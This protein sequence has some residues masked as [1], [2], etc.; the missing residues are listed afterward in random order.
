MLRSLLALSLV[1][2]SPPSWHPSA[3][4][5]GIAPWEH[6]EVVKVQ[7]DEGSGTAFRVGPTNLLSVNH[8]TSL[9]GCTINGAPFKVVQKQGDFTILS[10]DQKADRWLHIDCGGFVAGKIYEAE[11]FARGLDTLTTV[12]ATATGEKLGGFARLVGVF[13]WTPGQSGGPVI[14]LTTGNVVGTVNVYNA[15]RGDS[16]SV[17]LSTTPVCAHV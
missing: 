13:T 10:S 15:E 7:C 2:L 6:P 17:P 14:D 3:T 5:E 4:Q 8:V 12:D 1:A 16:G 11:G 9:H